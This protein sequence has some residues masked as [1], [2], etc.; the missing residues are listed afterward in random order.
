MIPNDISLYNVFDFLTHK[1]L[2]DINHLI[3][4]IAIALYSINIALII[5]LI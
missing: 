3:M 5:M 4:C 1:G 2:F